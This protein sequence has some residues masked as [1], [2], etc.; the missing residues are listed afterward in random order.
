[1]GFRSHVWLRINFYFRFLGAEDKY[2]PFKGS[3]HSEEEELLE[4]NFQVLT[5]ASGRKEGP[6][7]ET[8]SSQWQPKV[9]PVENSAERQE[10]EQTLGHLRGS[11]GVEEDS[12]NC[13]LHCDPEQEMTKG[14][15]PE[16]DQEMTQEAICMELRLPA[17]L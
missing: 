8:A 15:K 5:L 6:D 1:M 16:T 12:G 13:P 4:D 10:E 14:K 17:M 11:T 9:K 2:H 3:L 7:L